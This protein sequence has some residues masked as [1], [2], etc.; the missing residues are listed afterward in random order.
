V[1]NYCCV[2]SGTFRMI[3]IY[4]NVY[5]ILKILASWRLA[6]RLYSGIRFEN[7]P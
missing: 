7:T 5:N 4:Y 3:R 2:S 6:I 1:Y